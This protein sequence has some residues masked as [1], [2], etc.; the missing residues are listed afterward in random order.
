LQLS[1]FSVNCSLIF[2]ELTPYERPFAAA[3]AGF[4]FVEFWWPFSSASPGDTE[5]DAFVGSLR[6]AGVSLSML[7]FFAG[8]MAAGERG[9]LSSVE[10][11]G[12]YRESLDVLI[13]LAEQTGCR[14]FNALYGNRHPGSTDALQDAIAL[15]RLAALSEFTDSTGSVIVLEPLSGIESYPLL[16]ASQ[17]IAIIENLRAHGG[18]TNVKLLADLYHLS[19]NGDDVSRVLATL[20][21]QIGHVQIADAPGRS[22]PGSGRLPIS[23][24]L[25]EL[26]AAEYKEKIGLEYRPP[27]ASVD[28]FTWLT[29]LE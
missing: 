28:C 4:S 10:R 6:D 13:H 15:E 23:R 9:V 26:D 27:A 1:K 11:G 14:V 3:A 2:T 24:W 17:V 16:T 25:T 5:V 18:T 29:R 22:E 8:N 20:A 12:E 7:N 21:S 19:V